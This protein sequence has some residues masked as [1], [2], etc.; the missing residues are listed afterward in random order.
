MEVPYLRLSLMRHLSSLTL[1]LGIF[2]CQA[3][4]LFRTRKLRKQAK[5][6]GKK[7]DDLPE[8]RAYQDT[9][10]RKEPGA[11]EPCDGDVEMQE[12]V[13]PSE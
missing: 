1:E 5:L 6:D 13:V 11:N 3:I 12:T 4:F 7:F 8:A 2:V 9:R 10:T